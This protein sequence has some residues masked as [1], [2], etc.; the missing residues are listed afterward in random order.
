M[1]RPLGLLAL[2]LLVGCGGPAVPASAALTPTVQ[3]ASG[4]TGYAETLLHRFK[5]SPDAASPEAGVVLDAAGN[6]YGTTIEGGA[7]ASC[8]GGYGNGCGA[9]FEI[10]AEGTEHLVYSF[11]GKPDASEPFAAVILKHGVLFGTTAVGGN[12]YPCYV[13]G[14]DG[15]GTVFKI[16]RNGS[17]SLLY[18]FKGTSAAASQTVK[19]RRARSP[20]MAPVPST[21]RRPTAERINTARSSK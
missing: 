7:N 17:E 18:Q 21:A 5:G 16:D 15:C 4:T 14:G 11:A 3:R 9:V 8:P 20:P 12:Y 19:T 10:D 1:L 13:Y 2:L 6:V